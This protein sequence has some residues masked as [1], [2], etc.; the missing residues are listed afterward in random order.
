M[1][2][3]HQCYL[4]PVRLHSMGRLS[5]S[6]CLRCMESYADCWHLIWNCPIFQGFW[7]DVTYLLS[8]V[9]DTEHNFIF[10][11]FFECSMKTL[12]HTIQKSSHV[13]L[14]FF[15]EGH[16]YALDG[17]KATYANDVEKFG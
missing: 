12:G 13:K 7:K 16:C 11:H 8:E 17:P 4:T 9:L 10:L 14:Y 5:S 1:Y 15:Q 3:I 6:S 2:I